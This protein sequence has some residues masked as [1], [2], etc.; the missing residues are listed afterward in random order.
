[1][2]SGLTAFAFLFACLCSQA[3]TRH[4]GEIQGS[5]YIVDVPTE[6]TGDVLFLA[7]G[8]RPDTLPLA[9]D[10]EK[11]TAFFQSLLAS[12]WTIASPSFRGNDWI[13][14]DGAEDLIALRAHIDKEILSVRR[15]FLYGESMGGGIVSWLAEQ[16]PDQFDG[17]LAIGAYL[18]E[19]PKGETPVDPKLA[20]YLPGKPGYPIVLL[21]N[22]VEAEVSG[23]RDY[24]E[25]A[26]AAPFPPVLWTVER[27]GH[28]NINSAERLDG[29]QALV[30]WSESGVSPGARDATRLMVPDSSAAIQGK[31]AAGRITR[32]R[33]LYGNIYTS[34][35]AADLR[36]LGIGMGDRFDL[37]H[38]SQT[39]SVTFATT[40]S[41]VPQGEWV[42]FIDPEGHV[43]L[44]RN[45]A[46]ATATIGAER[47]DLLLI[48]AG[49]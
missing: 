37:T 34:F 22:N 19:E 6:A 14:A 31:V 48:V 35:V 18:Y 40:Y 9:A 39:V 47:D 30:A 38:G 2:R 12:G 29:F 24:V 5:R 49:E 42:A 36:Q 4:S 7:R 28:V 25:L 20:G 16:A 43:Q 41:D 26:A 27:P 46:N 45:Y 23:S 10:Y 21:T 13:M 1:M 8:Y 11:E 44:S 33:P 17:A 15:A 3:E 32:T